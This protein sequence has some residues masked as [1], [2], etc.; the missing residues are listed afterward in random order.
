MTPKPSSRQL[1][2]RLQPFTG[3]LLS[4]WICR[5]A[6]FYTVWPLVMLQHCLPELTS[7]RAANLDLSADQTKRLAA[8]LSVEPRAVRNMTFAKV[9]GISR[10]L[11]GAKPL[12]SCPH[13]CPVPSGCGAVLRSQLLG[14]RITCQLCG[15]VL[16]DKDGGEVDSLFCRYREAA[17]RRTIARRRGKARHAD[18]GVAGRYPSI[19]PDASNSE[20]CPR[21]RRVLALQ[22][23]WRNRPR[24]RRLARVT[25]RKSP[26]LGKSDPAFA[27]AMGAV[28][29][30]RHVDRGG[31]VMMR[32]LQRHTMG[33]NR[34]RFCKLAER[35]IAHAHRPR[36]FLQWQLI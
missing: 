6:S 30:R 14:W 7:L 29:R 26:R 9:P 11:I 21:R 28:G 10:R 25:P 27:P 5:H 19:A 36:A 35:S 15:E 12:Q 2:V 18:L 24:V 34:A 16:N 32:M 8:M 1:P 4:W 23:A 17:L 13:C 33:E 31:E 3:E 20:T 22:S